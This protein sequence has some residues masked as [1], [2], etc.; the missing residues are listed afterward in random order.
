MDADLSNS[1]IEFLPALAAVLLGVLLGRLVGA[2]FARG[3]AGSDGR[4]AR[5]IS[6]LVVVNLGL[7]IGVVLLPLPETTHSNLLQLLGLVGTG[8]IAVSST[9]FVSN[10][11]AGVMLRLVDAMRAGDFV[12]V[13]ETFGRISERGLFHTEIQTADRD[14]TTLPNLYLVTN[15]FTVVRSSGTIVT[16]DVSLGYDTPRTDV[17]RLLIEAATKAGLAEPFVR[18]PA[19]GDFAVQY[20]ICGFLEEVTRLLAAK[21]DLHREILDTLHAGG[22]EIMTPSVMAT[23][24]MDPEKAVIPKAAVIPVTEIT[25]SSDASAK[26]FDKAEE[27]QAEEAVE[28]KEAVEGG[29]AES[30]SPKPEVAGS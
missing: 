25:E 10:A 8:V 20:R 14:L 2:W 22:V 7:L 4:L 3:K 26:I 23:R 18:I 1:V 17:E 6:Q 24:P 5:Q 30:A 29:D 13:G 9:T 12:R 21:T 11:M 16:A 15:P 19:L 28:A 27:A